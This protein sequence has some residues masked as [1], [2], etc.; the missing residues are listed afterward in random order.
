M[1]KKNSQGLGKSIIKQRTKSSGNIKHA[2]NWLHCSE[3]DSDPGPSVQS[4]TEQTDLDDFLATAE[5]AG[6]EFAAEKLNTTII[7]ERHNDGLV[8]RETAAAIEQA[9][10]ENQHFLRIPRRPEWDKDMTVEELDQQ[11]RE[12]FLDWRRQLAHAKKNISS[13]HHLSVILSFLETA[14]KDTH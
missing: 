9:Q 5:L 8:S 2:N 11:E 3:L 14:F 12:S 10:Q 6:T 1:G 13:L 7:T 4:I